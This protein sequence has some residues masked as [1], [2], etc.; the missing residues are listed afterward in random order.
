MEGAWAAI[1]SPFQRG[2]RVEKSY[3]KMS[4]QNVQMTLLLPFL[5]SPN[6]NLSQDFPI[7]MGT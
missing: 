6:I 7:A 1:T 5:T 4:H 3:F 2:N